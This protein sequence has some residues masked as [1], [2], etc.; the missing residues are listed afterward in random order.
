MPDTK[1]R[2]KSVELLAQA[3]I[4]QDGSDQTISEKCNNL[5]TDIE[6]QIYSHH[7]QAINAEYKESIRSHIFN[8]KDAKNNL[9]N[10][11]VNDQLE[12]STFADMEGSDMAAPERRMSNDQLR[13]NSLRDSMAVNDLHPMERDLEDPE[14]GRD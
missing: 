2:S 8:L 10:R 3:L 14:R 9:R 11:L 4:G 5:A 1:I 13:R 6:Q 12:A 7:G